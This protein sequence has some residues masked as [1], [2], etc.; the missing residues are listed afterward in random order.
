MAGHF[1][2]HVR[3]VYKLPTDVLDDAFITSLHHKSGYDEQSLKKIVS[4]SGFVANGQAITEA[5]LTDFYNRLELF[6]QNT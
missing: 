5:Q 6:Y 1:L 3:T 2:E 4:F